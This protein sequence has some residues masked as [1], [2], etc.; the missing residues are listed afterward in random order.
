MAWS[1]FGCAGSMLVGPH[2]SAVDEGFLEVGVTRQLGKHRVPHLRPGPSGKAHIH[3]V[4]WAEFRWK[5]TP[6]TAGSR[7]PQ[8]GLDKQSIVSRRS[9]GVGDLAWQQ[10]G[11]PFIMG[12]AEHQSWH[13]VFPQ[14][15]GC[16]QISSKV[17]SPPVANVN[18]P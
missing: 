3:A 18:R 13:P 14:K 12:I 4:P 10:G 16:K 5:I 11:D 8:H 15:T 17:N 6:W 1:P 7:H 9:T 2:D